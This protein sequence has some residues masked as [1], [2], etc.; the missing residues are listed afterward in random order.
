MA[1]TILD[2]STHWRIRLVAAFALSILVGWGAYAGT[3]EVLTIIS[4]PAA[5]A[6]VA[7]VR[8]VSP[9]LR[10]APAPVAP[11]APATR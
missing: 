11:A 2:T 1:D 8:S 6:S 4:D 7:P 3:Y 5:A 10:P 9:V